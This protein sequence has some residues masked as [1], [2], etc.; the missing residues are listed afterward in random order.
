MPYGNGASGWPACSLEIW[1]A[2]VPW[3]RPWNGNHAIELF[4]A[5]GD[6]HREAMA[7]NSL[8]VALRGGGRVE[9]AIEAHGT[10]LEIYRE[11]EDWYRVGTA[12]QNL[13]LVQE[14]AHRPVEARA[15]LL[16]AA[17]A[18]TRGNALTEAAQARAWAEMLG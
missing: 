5:A 8:G 10:A 1:R 18:Y 11:F 17:D 3:R 15:H 9:E 16:Q 12:L 7:R 2:R 4:R 6:R 14:E 13:A